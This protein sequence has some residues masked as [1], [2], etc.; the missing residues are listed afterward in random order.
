MGLE[1]W[2]TSAWMQ[3]L[4]KVFFVLTCLKVPTHMSTLICSDIQYHVKHHCILV[5]KSIHIIILVGILFFIPQFPD[6][7]IFCIKFPV[8]CKVYTG[9]NAINEIE[10]G[11][12]VCAVE[13]SLAKDRGLSLRTGGQT[14]L[15]FPPVIRKECQLN[16]LQ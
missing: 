7:H 15:Y 4:I 12:S 8:M 9:Y 2:T 11:L 6:T 10:Q 16:W 1:P 5:L 3:T 14:I 13:N